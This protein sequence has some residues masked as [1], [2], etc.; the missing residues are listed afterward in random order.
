MCEQARGYSVKIRLI[1]CLLTKSVIG[2]VDLYAFFCVFC[3]STETG[4]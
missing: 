3:L 4:L 2:F 1:S